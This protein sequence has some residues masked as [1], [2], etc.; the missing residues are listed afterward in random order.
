MV[1]FSQVFKCGKS[2]LNTPL[3]TLTDCWESV[4]FVS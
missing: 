1:R 2:D 3:F 4:L